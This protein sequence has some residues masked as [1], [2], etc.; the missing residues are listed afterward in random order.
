M[1]NWIL[2]FL[3]ASGYMVGYAQ[4][5]ITVE[6]AFPGLSFIRPVD[7]QHAG[8]GSG[9]IFVVEQRGMIWVFSND[10]AVTSKTVFLDIRDRVND[11]GNEEGLLGL[12]F[13]PDY[14][15][16][17]YFYVD[18]TASNPRRTVISR[19]KVSAQDSNAAEPDSE[20]VILQVNQPFSNHNGGQIVFGP[21]SMLYIA[22][23]DGGAAGDPDENGQD[24]TTLLGSILRIDVDHTQPGMN[25]AIP[26]DNPFAGNTE[27]Y[28]EEIFAYG[29]RNPW[30]FSFDPVTGWL[31]C[32]DVGQNA[33]E[34]I[35]IIVSGGNYGWDIMEGFHC[36]EPPTGC[37]TTGLIMPI[38]EYSHNTGD[39]SVTG[40]FVYRGPGVPSLQGKYIYGDFGSGR[41]WSLDVSDLNNPVNVLVVD[42]PFNI[43]SFGVDEANELYMCAFDGRIYRFTPTSNGGLEN[44]SSPVED[45]Q[46]G[47]NYPNPFNPSTSIPFR[48][49]KTTFIR[50][51]IFNVRG[52][53]IKT[54]LDDFVSP[55]NHSVIWDG[56]DFQGREVASGIYFYHLSTSF[57]YKGRNG[58]VQTRKM[59]LLR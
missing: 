23:G 55:G 3:L 2:L 1:K 42:A 38:W 54:L 50:L 10:P 43:S 11:S 47:Q 16:N 18:Y 31:W 21:D 26:P 8:D 51:Q 22:L 7:L 59:V 39:I 6:Q 28:R 14:E 15:S 37:D 58:N 32:G 35:D 57:G 46:L 29:L 9:R 52:E 36:Y 27:G 40:G 5:P 17:G 20:F 53:W 33:W 24:L 19:F 44:P 4:S 25:Y 30:R 41:I 45:F 56:L 12:A 49:L 48:V 34:E 13:H